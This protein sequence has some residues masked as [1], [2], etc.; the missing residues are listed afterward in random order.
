MIALNMK[1]GIKMEITRRSLWLLAMIESSP[2]VDG[3][4]RLQKYALLLTKIILKNEDRYNDW[5]ANNYG[6]FSKQISL[7]IQQ[8]IKNE[9]VEK[10]TVSHSGQEHNRY[11]ITDKGNKMI[12]ELINSE[13][14][15]YRKIKIITKFYFNRSL[16]DLL[17][18][19]YTLFPKY[20]LNS[21]IKDTIRKVLSERNQ[22]PNLQYTLPFT[23]IKPNWSIISSTEQMNEF[24]FQDKEMREKLCKMI[25]L[26]SIPKIKPN[27]GEK[28]AGIL[29]DTIT[30]DEMSAVE[31]VRSVRGH[32]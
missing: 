9:M 31:I 32:N 27:S 10:N 4:T 20:T 13:K 2:Y 19:A 15:T 7:E 16:N 30:E 11:S 5:E 14:E 3:N 6:G 8:C 29:E 24:Q 12:K 1:E 25:G 21:R 18:D 17:T 22:N 23:T 26:D 28:L